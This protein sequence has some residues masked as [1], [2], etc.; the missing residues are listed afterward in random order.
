M[1]LVHVLTGNLNF[2]ITGGELEI[3]VGRFRPPH[4]ITS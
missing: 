2:I 3:A 4:Q 1:A